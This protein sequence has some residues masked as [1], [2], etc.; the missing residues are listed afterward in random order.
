MS[1]AYIHTSLVGGSAGSAF[2]DMVALVDGAHDGQ[3]ILDTKN[4]IRRIGIQ[5]DKVVEGLQT[6]YQIKPEF[7]TGGNP[8][9]AVA[10]GTYTT[11]SPTI[12]E[13]NANEIVLAVFGRAGYQTFY[14]RKLV[15]SLGFVIYDQSTLAVRV[16]GPFGN[17][18]GSNDGESFNISDPMAFGGYAQTSGPLALSG[19]SCYKGL[20]VE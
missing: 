19:L 3:L 7:Q 4:P 17:S 2:I 15:N 12:V 16:E 10:H 11:T 13:L 8:L 9:L 1:S 14:E 5:H 18:D 6:W 20:A